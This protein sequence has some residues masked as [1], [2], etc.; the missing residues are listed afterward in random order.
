LLEEARSIDPESLDVRRTLANAQVYAGH[1]GDAIE[2]VRWVLDRDPAYPYAANY[3]GQALVLSGRPVEA[4]RVY[5]E[6]NNEL[7]AGYV[8]G[9]LGHREEAEAIA[10]ANA[11][12]PGLQMFVYCGLG[13]KE[14]AFEAL[15]R[16]MVSN[17][18]RAAIWTMR[19]EAAILRDDPRFGLVRR[20]LGLP[21]GF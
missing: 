6:L 18:W 12:N 8:H 7:G 20:R 19:G 3:L 11:D 14:R 21:D 17:P 16:L 13:D 15:E 1:Y 10:A 2:S 4:L 9:V 5:R